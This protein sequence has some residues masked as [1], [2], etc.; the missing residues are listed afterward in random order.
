MKYISDSM[1]NEFWSIAFWLAWLEVR[2]KDTLS[3]VE[4]E[5]SVK[6]WCNL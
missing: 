4:V 1:E 6:L 2:G 5:D 3:A